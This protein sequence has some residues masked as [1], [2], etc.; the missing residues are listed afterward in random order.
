MPGHHSL[1]HF[2]LSHLITRVKAIASAEIGSHILS[3][4]WSLSQTPTYTYTHRKGRTKHCHAILREMAFTRARSSTMVILPLTYSLALSLFTLS[5]SIGIYRC[6]SQRYIPLTLEHFFHDDA[7]FVMTT[8]KRFVRC[9]CVSSRRIIR[10][11]VFVRIALQMTREK[12][13]ARKP[14]HCFL[15]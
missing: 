9:V 11:H 1:D 4:P 10:T 6:I 3:Q 5:L 8:H 15:D 12:F 14:E 7:F 2:A 13:F